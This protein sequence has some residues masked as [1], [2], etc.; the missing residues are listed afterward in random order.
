M[1]RHP[2]ANG[3]W[4]QVAELFRG[5]NQRSIFPPKWIALSALE[6]LVLSGESK[7]IRPPGD[8]DSICTEALGAG[9][10]GKVVW[11]SLDFSCAACILHQAG[12]GNHTTI[13]NTIPILLSVSIP[14]LW[15][16][17][18]LPVIGGE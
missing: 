16:R 4:R 13:V 5:P 15:S 3:R 17:R 6:S 12:P 14:L 7:L 10:V 9:A 2:R 18:G 1:F 8:M 11:V